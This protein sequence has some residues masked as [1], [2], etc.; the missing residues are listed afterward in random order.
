MQGRIHY[1]DKS[2]KIK[3]IQE[4]HLYPG[5]RFE[6]FNITSVHYTKIQEKNPYSPMLIEVFL[7][8]KTNKNC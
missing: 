8:E 3:E 7:D 2:I 4:F 5:N 1:P 6:N